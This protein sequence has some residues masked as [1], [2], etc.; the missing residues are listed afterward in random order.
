LTADV[1]RNVDLLV[2]MGCGEACP[3]V[4]GVR[5]VEWQIADPKDQPLESVRAIRDQIR[6][7]VRELIANEGVEQTRIPIGCTLSP[8]ELRDRRGELLPGLAERAVD[9]QLVDDGIRLRFAPSPDLVSA[10]ARVVDS[11][12]Q[13]CAFLRFDISVE[14]AGG[15]VTLTVSGPPEAQPLLA[16]LIVTS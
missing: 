12:R 2:T 15:P 14:P 6:S 1:T 11:E 4:P 13:C 10:I 7:L 3:V 16:E 9:R 8:D 5:V